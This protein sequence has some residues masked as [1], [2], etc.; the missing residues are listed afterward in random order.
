MRSAACLRLL[1]AT[2]ALGLSLG[3]AALAPGDRV[4]NFRLFDHTGASH[5]LYRLSDRKA[6]A[7]L[8]QGNGCPIVRN[9]MPRF[10]ELRE[11]FERQGVAFLGLNSNLQDTRATIAKEVT[12]FGWDLPVLDDDTQL[13]GESLGLVRTGEVFVVDPSDWSI[14]YHGLLDDRLSY[15]NQK[16]AAKH[17]YLRDALA[18]MVAGKPVETKST[19]AIG[20]LINFPE[21]KL[22]ASHASISYSKDIAPLLR[23][24]CVSC[25]REGGIGSW[26]MTGY[27][28]VRGFA[29]MI[30]E[31][32][33]TQR[34][35]P[36]HADPHVGSFSND[37]SLSSAEQARL[38]HWIEA[39]AMRGEG[40]DPLTTDER[41]WPEWALGEPDVVIDI[42]SHEVPATGT[43]PYQ[44]QRVKNPL[45]R[46][47]WVRAVDILP[48]DR[49]A[50]HHVITSFYVRDENGRVNRR[51]GGSLGGYVPGSVAEPFPAGTGTFLPKEAEIVFQ[52][53]YTAYGKPATDSSRFG[54]YLYDARPEHELENLVLMNR[55]IVI[56]ARSNGHAE[57]ARRTLTDDVMVYSLL[58]HAHFRGKASEFRAVFADGRDELLLSVP[59]YDFNWQTDYQLAQP[60]FLPAGTTIVHRT[61]WDNSATNPAN[62]DPDRDVPW[63]EQSWD[64]MLFG[65][66][67]YRVITPGERTAMLR[68]A[69]ANAGR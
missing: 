36:W 61:S 21:R 60:R 5:E 52:M 12:E 59:N 6:I 27:D 66:I 13:V 53:H 48:G 50:L 32:V 7:V 33:R 42:P 10:S 1:F 39:G 18:A 34:M 29:P 45:G 15:E 62:P 30:R 14:A 49:K 57:T 25:H 8:V 64:E 22:K 65:A 19:R 4:D 54:L 20:C 46:D 26:A 55:R 47:A 37:R 69:R 3:A 9:A 23:D 56:P 41:A 43:V 16:Q 24:K 68:G 63:G 2:F 58:P 51:N 28:M 17:H 44:Y 67:S 40:P 11:L 38:V 31:V 35:P